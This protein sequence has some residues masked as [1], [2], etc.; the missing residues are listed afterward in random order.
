MTRLDPLLAMAAIFWLAVGVGAQAGPPPVPEQILTAKSV[1][2]ANGGESCTWFTGP[3]R[4]YRDLYTALQ[5]WGRYEL[6]AA[7][8]DADLVFSVS[9]ACPAV[10]GTVTNGTGTG[11]NFLPTLRLRILQSRTHA[12]LWTVNQPV[13]R[14]VLQGNRNRNFDR[15]VAAL[16][17]DLQ[18][19]RANLPVQPAPPKLRRDSAVKVV[20]AVASVVAMVAIFLVARHHMRAMQMRPLPPLPTPTPPPFPIF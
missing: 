1:F 19:L 3:D 6:V 7:P 9:F 5:K 20:V 8:G 18:D 14:A 17:A 15:A 12:L 10:P 16:V 4:A 13:E 2:L 11:P